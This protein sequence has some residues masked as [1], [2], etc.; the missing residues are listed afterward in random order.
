MTE[1]KQFATHVLLPN[2]VQWRVGVG[3]WE[4]GEEKEELKT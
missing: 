1:G 3:A 4:V 2:A